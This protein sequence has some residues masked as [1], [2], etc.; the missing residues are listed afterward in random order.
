MNVPRQTEKAGSDT[1]LSTSS[2]RDPN[3]HWRQKKAGR[4]GRSGTQPSP[5]TSRDPDRQARRRRERKS[6]LLSQRSVLASLGNEHNPIDIEAYDS[7]PTSASDSTDTRAQRDPAS[8]NI[9]EENPEISGRSSTPDLPPL[10]FPSSTELAKR[11]EDLSE[12]IRKNEE[13]R[14]KCQAHVVAINKELKLYKEQLRVT[15]KWLELRQHPSTRSQK[16]K[17]PSEQDEATEDAATEESAPST[18]EQ[19]TAI[20][21]LDNVEALNRPRNDTGPSAGKMKNFSGQPKNSMAI[22]HI[23][24]PPSEAAEGG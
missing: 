10:D 4:S 17:K 12:T 13:L 5:S 20:I 24:E 21:A 3:R 18:S 8:P 14:D 9:K 16:G 23:V 6:H 15:R 7:K 2:S 11:A 1:Q 19:R 22:S